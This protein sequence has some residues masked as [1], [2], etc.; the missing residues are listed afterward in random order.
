MNTPQVLSEKQKRLIVWVLLPL[1]SL[2]GMAIDLI[3]PSLPAI[4]SN[5]QAAA[6]TTKNLITF[7]LLGLALGNFCS[8]F[9]T[10]ALGRKHILRM[11]LIG[12]FIVS[13][14]PVII[15]KMT[16]LLVARFFQGIAIGT[17]AVV[18]RAVTSDILPP[19][20]IVKVGTLMGSM[21]G[22]GAVIGPLIGGY[23]QFYFGWQAGFL[24]FAI[25]IF[26]AFIVVFFVIPET[27]FQRHPLK[28]KTIQHHLAE[29]FGHQQFMVLAMMMGVIYSLVIVFNTA[30]PFFI[31]TI[32]HHTPI[33]FGNMALCLGGTYLGATFACR[34]YLKKYPVEQLLTAVIYTS[35]LIAMFSWGAALLFNMNVFFLFGITI[36]M[37]FATGFIFPMCMGKGLS[38][39]RHLAGT[40]ASAMFLV[41]ILIQV[42][43]AFLLSLIKVHSYSAMIAGYVVLLAICLVLNKC[44]SKHV[45]T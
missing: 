21:Y 18:V 8:G 1:L 37:F 14:L 42:F 36:A 12:F 38:L 34:C 27:H 45:Q 7:Y 33:F 2:N 24:F 9:L 16:I 30:G 43:F 29:V 22:F 11:G 4:A 5:L 39:F 31:Q 17:I 35:F 40:A 13:L 41:N 10:D 19:E 44:F 6:S 26:I 32:L 20:K 15:P 23:L 25:F 28:L 3:A